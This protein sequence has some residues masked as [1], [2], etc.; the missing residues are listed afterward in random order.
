MSRRGAILA[1]AA[2]WSAAALACAFDTVTTAEGRVAGKVTQMTP[3]EVTVEQ[4]AGITK[5]VPVNEIETISFEDEPMPLKNA[6]NA[7]RAGRY[8]DALKTLEE[9]NASEVER[10]EIKQDL[11]FYKALAACK[12]AL[13]GSGTIA[14]A[15]KQMAGFVRNNANSYHYLEA[16]EV[17]GDLLIAA[18]KQAAAQAYYE[19]VAKAPWPDYKM[20]AGVAIGRALL[21]QGKADDA[22]KQFQTVI[23]TSASGDLAERQ[24]LAAK[25]GKAR[26]L[27]E[28]KQTDE[29]IKLAQEIIDKADAEETELN[30]KAYNVLGIA[31]RKAGRAKDAL[32]AFLHVD[33]LYPSDGEAHVEALQNLIPLWKEL[34]KPERAADAERV[35]KDQYGRTP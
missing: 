12:S 22:M 35:L 21:S 19:Q 9:V 1:M 32:W 11:E 33:I 7:I 15:G 23:D 20:R 17:V 29:A 25:L 34:Q 5:G 6:R 27:A 3:T 24:R 10:A 26:C 16:C 28:S 8:E 31:Y 30:A 2:W 13:A 14:E 18:G 4:A